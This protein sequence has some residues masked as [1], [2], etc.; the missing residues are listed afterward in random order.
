MGVARNGN[1]GIPGV[2][3]QPSIPVENEVAAHIQSILNDESTTSTYR[4]LKYMY[5][6]MRAQIFWDGNKRTALIS[7]NYIMLLNGIGVLHIDESKL[8]K[9]NE[10]LS[11]FYETNDD[12]TIIQ[13]TYDH[14]I[15]GID[16]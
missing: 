12:E 6:A 4:A 10:L 3:Y 8:E 13:W 5:F 7:A 2:N 15:F 14:C 1:V 9:W 11:T 16:Y